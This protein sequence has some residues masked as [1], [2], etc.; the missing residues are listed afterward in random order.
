MKTITFKICH[1]MYYYLHVCNFGRILFRLLIPIFLFYFRQKVRPRTSP[2][3]FR[4]SQPQDFRPSQPQERL[5]DL[6]PV[7]LGPGPSREPL[8][9]IDLS[10]DPAPPSP[11]YQALEVKVRNELS[12]E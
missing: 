10:G 9:I 2:E 7:G 11:R 6:R 8:G 12:F 4:P 3:H 1:E 5:R